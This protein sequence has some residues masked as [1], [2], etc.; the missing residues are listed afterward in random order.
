MVFKNKL[1][2]SECYDTS[3]TLEGFKSQ[4][5]CMSEGISKFKKEGFECGLNCK[6]NNY[7]LN[8]CDRICNSAGCK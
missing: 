1:N 5:D 6:T 2:E 4:K 7:G 8:I 3:Y